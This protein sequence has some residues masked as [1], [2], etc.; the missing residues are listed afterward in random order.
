MAVVPE[1][2]LA[3]YVGAG[4]TQ[5]LL[6]P[7]A[8][9]NRPKPGSTGMVLAVSGLALWSLSAA[10]LY[11]TSG[12]AARLSTM[13]VMALG[14]ML[15]GI[16][17]F[18][19]ATEFTGQF[20]PTRRVLAALAVPV[21]LVQAMVWTE[22]LHGLM[23]LGE[24]PGT[25][26]EASFGPLYAVFLVFGFAF[27]CTGLAILAVEAMSSHGIRR[28]QCAV[29]SVGGLPPIVLAA[30]SIAGVTGTSYTLAPFG[31][32][33]TVFCYAWILFRADALEIAPVGRRR[34]VEE[35]NDAA[36][37]VSE[38]GVVVDANPAAREIAGAGT[39]AIGRPIEE[40]FAD[41]PE[42][43]ELAEA[44][45]GVNTELSVENDGELHHYHLNTSRIQ[46]GNCHTGIRLLVLR[47]VTPLKRREN[48]LAERERQLDLLR[49]VLTRALRHNIRNDLTVVRGYAKTIQQEVDSE[50]ETLAEGIVRKCDGLVDLSN[51]A[52]T[53]QQQVNEG[54]TNEHLDLTDVLTSI[55]NR[56]RASN[57]DVTF[58]VRMPESCIVD[59]DPAMEFAFE[60]LIE[61]A[62]EH[63]DGDATVTIALERDDDVLVTIADDGP[64]I[65][66]Y[67]LE[68]LERGEET[69]L[70]HGS[71]IGLWI[72]YWIVE[73]SK[74][75]ITFRSCEDGTRVT[76]GLPAA[77]LTPV[78]TAPPEE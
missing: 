20:D 26:V 41:L 64:G 5:L 14:G 68:V 19:I 50:H 60:N 77:Q 31:S 25:G 72:V 73:H 67:E 10:V 9:R 34:L 55:V 40:F 37:T 45:D 17:Y 74:A 61:N 48:E 36:V 2:V 23:W 13:A 21:V 42:A 70:E 18:L 6:V 57:P 33:V 51:K 1:W 78:S 30:V 63:N 4:L 38:Q 75:S 43:V 69:P 76:I 24:T 29:L 66:P 46:A 58:E 35:M 27:A 59:I 52:A 16:G 22:P 7:Y 32:M 8:L 62:I 28:F 3:A 65:P 56:Y 11:A 12:Y 44:E 53:I 54:E 49:Q 47:D 39:D 15:A 71:G